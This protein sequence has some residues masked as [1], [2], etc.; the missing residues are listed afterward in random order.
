MSARRLESGGRIDRQQRINFTWDGR[1]L[2]GYAG[3]TLASALLAR[4]EKVLGRS[5][6]YHRPRGIMS[7]GVEESGAM[8]T[9]GSG[10]RRD[11]NV[12]ATMQE[13]Y[14]GLVANGQNAW[15]SVRHDVGAVNSLFGRF[16]AAGFYYKTF[17]GL[18]LFEW[19]SK[20][21]GLWMKYEKII[22][23]AAGMGTA[24]READPDVYDHAHAFCDVLVV[25]AG[26]AGLQAALT[27]ARAGMEVWLVEQDCEPGG[28]LL[29]QNDAKLEKQRLELV[30]ELEQ[31]GVRI[32]T[33]TTVF[34]LYDNG[35]AGL[36]ERVTDHLSTT[37]VYL[38]RQRFWTLRARHTIVASGAMERGVAFGNNDR[39]GIM[40]ASAGRA[41]LNRYAVLGG[42][43]IVVATNNDSA[44]QGAA[45]LAAAGARVS[46]LDARSSVNTNLLDIV[47]KAKISLHTGTAP[48]NAIGSASISRLDVATASPAGWDFESRMNCDL[49]LVSGGWSPVVHLMSHRGVKPVWNAE[50]ACFVA[51]DSDESIHV[52]GSAAGIWNTSACLDSGSSVG[53]KVVK[54]LGGTARAKAMPPAGGWESPIK[55]VYEV[56]VAGRKTK[57]IVDP[58]HDVTADDIR[59]A[60]REG[61]VSVEHLKR[62]T[63]LGMATDGG[64]VGNII[65]LALMAEALG[66]D[67]ADVG[68]TTFRPPYTPVAIGA[69]KGRNVDEHFRPL[70][71]TPMH[72][73]NL[74]HGATM[75]MAGLWHRPWFFA[76]NAETISE[77]YVRETETTRATVGLCDVTSLGKIA[78]Q[79]PDATEFLNRVYTNPFAKLPIGK[80]RYGIMLRDDGMV[81]DD[82][83][84][85]RFSETDYF[86]TT[87]TAHAG[88]VMVWL[89]ELL[90]T[91][92]QDLRVHV[93]SVSEQWAGSAVAGPRSRDVLCACVED[94]EVMSNDNFPFMGVIET[95]LRGGIPCRIARISFSGEL[96]YETYVPSDYAPALMELLWAEAQKH[97]GCLYGLEALG[98]MRIEKGHVT[99][100]ELDGRVSIDDA[101]LGKMANPDKAYIGKAMRDRPEL[102]SED[103]PRLVGIK[104]IDKSET[105]NAGS[106]L[107]AANQV[108]GMGEGWITGVTHSPAMGHWIG[109][110]FI[111]GGHEAWQGKTVVAADPVRKGNINVEIISPHMYDP[112]GEK[113]YG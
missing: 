49:L 102:L 93:T 39:P 19:F 15:P 99:G 7:A 20:G 81:M 6:K 79:G 90:Q 78:V 100:A 106:I 2:K 45:E 83:T 35:T 70:R 63:T 73:W 84:T 61:F 86:M 22:L 17:M 24:S 107:C 95:T 52:V 76:R 96:A 1:S 4:N 77:A 103:R 55:P 66:I 74:Q 28:D 82:G 29:N 46:L 89:E 68:T 75:T 97:D 40:N 113:M 8:V 56:R 112:S 53:A 58:Q 109:L 105:F 72:D 36:L 85:W 108:S 110:G 92:W 10:S 27:V 37:P 50:Q 98:A 43:Q 51:P 16:L 3:D 41:Y 80:A 11:P 104:P 101:G 25:G 48:L 34:G 21:T 9:I 26:P 91:R 65:G 33:R 13:L 42:E 64:K 32:M 71:R 23:K 44:Y 111:K 62:Y 12:K 38:P 18:P 87:T 60:H 69:L 47:G 14:Q 5:F 59:L 31:A 94:P 30:A 54:A 88:K 67:I 57:A